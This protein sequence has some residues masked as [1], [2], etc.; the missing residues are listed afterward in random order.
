MARGRVTLR[1]TIPANTTA[2]VFVP[3]RNAG[4]VTESGVPVAKASAVSFVRMEAG[5]AIFA[6]GSGDYTFIAKL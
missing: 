6:V 3:A 1:V 5:A 4:S 2:L